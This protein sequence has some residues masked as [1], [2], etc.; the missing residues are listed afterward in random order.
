MNCIWILLQ[1]FLEHVSLILFLR[2]IGN[3]S[4][5]SFLCGFIGQVPR[6]EELNFQFDLELLLTKPISPSTL[7]R[8]RTV[9]V[10]AAIPRAPRRRR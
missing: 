8:A 10:L 4:H 7:V 5:L 3:F 1:N 9:P 2:H 6:A